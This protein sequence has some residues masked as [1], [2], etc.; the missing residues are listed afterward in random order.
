MPIAINPP[1]EHTCDCGEH[2]QVF[3]VADLAAIAASPS[4]NGQLGPRSV[5]CPKCGRS[6]LIDFHQ[7]KKG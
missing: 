3:E 1:Y 4:D 7:L 5:T 2:F 6:V